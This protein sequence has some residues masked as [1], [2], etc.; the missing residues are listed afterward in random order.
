MPVS[1]NPKADSNIKLL[2]RNFVIELLIYGTLIIAYFFAV[3]R[4]LESYLTNLFAENLTLYAVVGLLLIV[5]QGV[6]LDL[7]TT[8][9]LNQIKLDRFD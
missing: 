7:I 5:V 4:Y 8:F 9:L 3:L 6:L 1:D 2:L